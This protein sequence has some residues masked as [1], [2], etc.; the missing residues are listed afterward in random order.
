MY[1]PDKKEAGKRK[2]TYKLGVM[3][4]PTKNTTVKLKVLVELSTF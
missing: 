2:I 4:N 3:G 1:K